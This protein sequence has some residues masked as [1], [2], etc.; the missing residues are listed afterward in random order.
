MRPHG[1][2]DYIVCRASENGEPDLS[3]I[4]ILNGVVFSK[5]YETDNT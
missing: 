4:W 2:G 3:D 5:Y 1:E